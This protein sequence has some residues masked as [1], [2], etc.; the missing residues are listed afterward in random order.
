MDADLQPTAKPPVICLMGPTAAGKTDL[1]LYLAERLPCELISVDSALVYRG[2]DIGTAKP[3]AATLQAFPHHLVDILD[4]AEAYSAARFVSDVEPLISDIHRRGR[5]PLLVGGTMLYYR[6]WSAGL[7]SMPAADQ[8]LRASLE[9][10]AAQ[11][12]WP[13]L[14]AELAAVDPEA[15]ARIHPNDPQRIQRALEVYLLSGRPLSVWHALQREENVTTGAGDGGN[16]PYTVR[17]LAIAPNERQVL[18]QRIAQRF[19][20]MIEQ[21]FVD[22]VERLYA[23]GDLHPGLPSIRAVGYRQVWDYLQGNLSHEAMVER[24]VIATR[25]LAKRQF[26]WLRGWLAPVDWLD[27]LDSRRFDNALKALTDITI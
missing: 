12:G 8:A 19:S 22:E 27:S 11:Q 10:R 13:A 16:L 17:W 3:D 5:I 15:A 14:H 1:A 6:A 20:L 24:G 26:T 21:G 7:A 23:R 25:Q 18:H 4:P 2:M 9:L